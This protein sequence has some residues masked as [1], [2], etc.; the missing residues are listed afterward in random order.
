MDFILAAGYSLMARGDLLRLPK[1]ADT[2]GFREAC[3]SYYY[4]SESVLRLGNFRFP[5]WPAI[6]SAQSSFSGT[7]Q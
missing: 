1:E 5:L 6:P 4:L 3:P 2:V 7:L